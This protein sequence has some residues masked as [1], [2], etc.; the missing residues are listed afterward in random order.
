MRGSV[1]ADDGGIPFAYDNGRAAMRSD[2]LGHSDMVHV[3]VAYENGFYC[4]DSEPE[5]REGSFQPADVT[6]IPRI[7]QNRLV[8]LDDEV[9]IHPLCA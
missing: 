1:T 5:L 2:M 4:L 3:V 6:R 8:V 7:D 9:E